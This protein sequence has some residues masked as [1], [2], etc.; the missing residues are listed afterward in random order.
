MRYTYVIALLH[1]HSL[2]RNDPWF[3]AGGVAMETSLM[4]RE[5]PQQYPG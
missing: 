3:P 2:S 5:E 1:T 4:L